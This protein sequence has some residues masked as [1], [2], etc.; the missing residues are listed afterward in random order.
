[1]GLF[2]ETTRPF[3][4]HLPLPSLSSAVCGADSGAQ[5]FTPLTKAVYNGKGAAVTTLVEQGASLDLKN[6]LGG[7]ALY[8]ASV[9][10]YPSIVKYLVAM[11][12]K[13]GID[14]SERGSRFGRTVLNE[15]TSRG[16]AE[17]VAILKNP[18]KVGTLLFLITSPS[19]AYTS[20]LTISLFKRSTTGSFLFV[21]ERRTT[22]HPFRAC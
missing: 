9:K 12:A 15:A 11:G 4:R 18:E 22:S 10:N 1:M 21:A 6:N 16:H 8:Y 2:N 3:P 7:T 19:H 13:L 20:H 17:V 5:G 14:F